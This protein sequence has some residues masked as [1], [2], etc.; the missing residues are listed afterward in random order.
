MTQPRPW[1]RVIGLDLGQRRIGLA[2]ANVLSVGS[3]VVV[4]AGFLEIRST[5]DALVGLKEIIQE[6]NVDA[7]VIGMPYVNG[8]PTR[9]T[10]KCMEVARQLKAVLPASMEMYGWDESYS[11]TSAQSLLVDAELKHSGKAKRGRV[12]AVAAALILQSFMDAHRN[13]GMA[14]GA[15]L[16]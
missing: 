8:L 5:E 12:D 11:S 6:E 10:D 16:L 3:T 4:P 14:P 1:E 15:L 2:F 9:Q 13:F 7:V